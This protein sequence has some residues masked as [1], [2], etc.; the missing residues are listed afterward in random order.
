MLSIA[1]EVKTFSEVTFSYGHQH[2]ETPVLAHQQKL[3]FICSY[4]TQDAV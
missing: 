2:M 4:Q 1:E 3:I